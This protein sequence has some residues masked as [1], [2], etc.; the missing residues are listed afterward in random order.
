MRFTGVDL[1]SRSIELITIEED[2]RI[3]EQRQVA[4][5]FAPLE[6]SKK[7]LSE[8]SCDHI[9]ATGYG[10]QL[11]KNE[12]DVPVVSEILAHGAAAMS[13]FPQARSVLDIGGQDTK[14]ICIEPGKGVKKFEMND[15]CAAGTGKFLEVMANAFDKDI[16]EFGTFALSGTTPVNISNMCTV[17]AESEATSMMARGQEP[18]NIALGLHQSIASRS[19]NMLKRINAVSPV[20]FCGGVA[21]NQCV[22]RLLSELPGEPVLIPEA[23]QFT[24]ALGAALLIA[25]KK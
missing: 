1:G 25:E 22:C 16:A 20:V 14:A 18:V 9:Q 24:G 8:S 11:F 2:G 21:R 12:L 17:F 6:N 4:T 3:V 19:V 5:A 13:L 10:R 7:L 23:P 15:R